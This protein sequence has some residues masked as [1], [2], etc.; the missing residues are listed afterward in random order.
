MNKKTLLLVSL[1]T[2]CLTLLSACASVDPKEEFAR[3]RQLTKEST[4]AAEVFDPGQPPMSQDEI[5]QM[6]ADGLTLDEALALALTNSRRLQA[7]FM[8]IGVARADWVQ[9]GLLRNP[10]LG[11]AVLLPDGGGS[12]FVEASIA[13]SVVDLWQLPVRRRIAQHNLDAAVLRI[14]RTAGELAAQT[15]RGYYEA[16]AAAELLRV[17]EENLELL[18]TSHGAIRRKREAGAA[19]RLDDDL[20]LSLSLAGELDV[21][22]ARLQTANSKRRL[23]RLLSID[24]EIEAI[25]LI[26]ALPDTV[27]PD[28]NADGLIAAARSH[29]LDLR[30]YH[31]LMQ[32]ADVELASERRRAWGNVE[33]GA[34]LESEGGEN[35]V[36]PIL[37]LDIPIF[38][39]NHAQVG[40]RSYLSRR[41]IK[42][43]QAAHLEIAQDIRITLD[44]ARTAM[45]SFSFYRDQLLPQAQRNLEITEQ[46]YEA[47]QFTI[48]GLVESQRRLLEARRGL[49]EAQLDA[50]SA[51][52][53]LDLIVGAPIKTVETQD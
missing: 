8:D 51:M 20:A 28:L 33:A 50:A 10:T 13:Q 41:A 17:A 27:R 12:T 47:G 42:S 30:M 15:R 48:L 22:S 21:R 18:H 39:R 16:V 26:D 19:S 5:S 37:S 49:I 9:S 24:T 52:A 6:L 4:G 7:E 36:G 46:A 34:R 1:G 23:A 43:Y 2:C 53:D 35:K 31:A 14:A 3:A 25:A 45:E 32:A 40:R 11:L 44:T 29:R 38:D